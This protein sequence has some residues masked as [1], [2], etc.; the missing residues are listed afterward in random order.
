MHSRK[1]AIASLL[2]A[3][4]SGSLAAMCS[5]KAKATAVSPAAADCRRISG[6]SMSNLVVAGSARWLGASGFARPISSGTKLANHQLLT[7]ES[8]ACA[9][10]VE[11]LRCR[12]GTPSFSHTAPETGYAVDAQA[13]KRREWVRSIGWFL[14]A[15]LSN[16]CIICGASGRGHA[17]RCGC[18]IKGLPST[19][20]GMA[21]LQL[22]QARG[23]GRSRK[24]S[25]P[26]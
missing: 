25:F 3:T 19:T 26:R 21:C 5:N 4:A 18:W 13:D 14:P 1:T 7:A 23:G 15:L 11:H 6:S 10:S 2:L 20:E 24:R 16:G 22:T 9:Y 17:M 12:V 8:A